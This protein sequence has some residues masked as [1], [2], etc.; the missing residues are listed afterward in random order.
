MN[1]PSVDV[2]CLRDTAGKVG[3]LG[4]FVDALCRFISTVGAQD[5]DLCEE[6]LDGYAIGGLLIG[7]RMAGSELQGHGEH[8][9]KLISD[10]ESSFQNSVSA[11]QKPTSRN[12]GAGG[13]Q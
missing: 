6:A 1:R 7:L 4:Y 3:N 11:P 2:E 5:P 12:R 13:M 9:E 8:L 10:A